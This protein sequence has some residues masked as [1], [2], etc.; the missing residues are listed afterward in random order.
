MNLFSFHV[1]EEVFTSPLCMGDTLTEHIEFWVNRSFPF[2]VWKAL[3]GL[4]CSSLSPTALK[5]LSLALSSLIS[6]HLDVVFKFLF[7]FLSQSIPVF[8]QLSI[9]TQSI[10]PTHRIVSSLIIS[11]PLTQD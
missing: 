4:W 7:F 8:K 9:N 3:C 11:L 5:F 10:F 2:C 1:L 6:V